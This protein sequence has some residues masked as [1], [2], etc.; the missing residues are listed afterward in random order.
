MIRSD[1]S[2]IKEKLGDS[3]TPFTVHFD[4]TKEELK[5]MLQMLE[6]YST[7]DD[8]NIIHQV[9]NAAHLG[10][11]EAQMAFGDM[12][13]EGVSAEGIAVERDPHEAIRWY[14]KAADQN[15]AEAQHRLSELRFNTNGQIQTPEE[16]AEWL[17]LSANNGFALA[18]YH[19][20]EVYL[21]GYGVE[22][23]YDLA[24]EWYGKAAA[25]GHA[26][27]IEKLRELQHS[28]IK[29]SVFWDSMPLKSTS[30]EGPH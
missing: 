20:A 4:G 17:K 12:Y 13:M 30:T 16:M 3:S 28:Q 1:Y 24:L 9:M 14:K 23:N 27:S 22:Y 8:P 19:L 15:F 5:Q 29:S 10:D 18:Q 7:F 21:D 11:P 6:D 26:A 2:A 25:Q